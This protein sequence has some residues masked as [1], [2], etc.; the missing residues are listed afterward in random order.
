[1]KPRLGL[2]VQLFFLIVLPLAGLLM[3]V[4]FGSVLVHQNEMRRMVGER[5]VIAVRAA[6]DAL[7]GE[8]D[9]R[10]QAVRALAAPP[11]SAGTFLTQSILAQDEF[12]LGLALVDP[13]GRLLAQRQWSARLP[14]PGDLALAAG[15]VEGQPAVLAPFDGLTAGLVLVRSAPGGR[16]V[17]GAFSLDP[18]F[19]QVSRQIMPGNPF[20]RLAIVDEKL[21]VLYAD[22]P[23]S[24]EGSLESHAGVAQ[25]L[26]G[27]SGTLYLGSSSEEHV[28]AY[29]PAGGWAPSWRNPGSR[30]SARCSTPPR[31]ARW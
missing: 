16:A 9:R 11:L 14:R 24:F 31:S 10:T 27:Q 19:Q 20:R 7:R 13:A 17:L 28:M 8:I 1:M 23:E 25:A 12:D 29:S 26:A 3:L 2:M 30:S 21:R 6:A 5:D 15:L 4:S 22:P 18:L